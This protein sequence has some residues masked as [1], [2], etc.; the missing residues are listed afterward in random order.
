MKEEHLEIVRQEITK[1][2]AV[3]VN[4]KIDN[5]HDILVKQN[6]KTDAVAQRLVSHLEKEAEFQA[7]IREHMAT[8]K[9][10]LDG[11]AGI[12]VLRGFLVWIG[13]AVAAWIVVKNNLRL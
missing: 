11:A 10:Y 1:A 6:E 8:V 12:K 7:E 5:L 13:G 9:P 2:V 4:G 3:I